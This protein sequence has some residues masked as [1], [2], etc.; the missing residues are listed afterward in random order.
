MTVHPL[1]AYRERVGVTLDVLAERVGVSKATL[2]RVENG[3]QSPS[4]DLVGR[5]KAESHGTL[6]ADDF[7]PSPQQAPN[8]SHD[9][10]NAHGDECSSANAGE[11]I[12]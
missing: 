2:S 4:L 7:L 9:D 6:S 5:L 3:K 1:Q 12:S 11:V 8:D 10:Q